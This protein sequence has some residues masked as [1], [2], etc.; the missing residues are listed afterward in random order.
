MKKNKTI[1]DA[2][3]LVFVHED[4]I[5]SIVRQNFLRAF[6]GY[7]AFPGGKVDKEDREYADFLLQAA[8]REA[9]EELGFDILNDAVISIDKIGL[10]LSPEFNPLRFNTHFYR[11]NLK[12]KPDFT[13]DENEAKSFCWLTP[14]QLLESYNRGERLVVPP[15]R[16]FLEAFREDLQFKHELTFK[17]RFDLKIEVPAIEPIKN[18]IQVMP[19]SLTVPPA[20]RTNAFL[21]GNEAKVLIDPSP[22]DEGELERFLYSIKDYKISKMMITHHH[23]DHHKYA[24]HIARK[25]GYDIHLS[26]DTYERILKYDEA[27]FEGIN[28]NFLKE[29]DV[30]CDWLDEQVQVIEVPGHDEGQLALMPTS[31]KWFLA[32][33]LFQGIGTVVVGGDEGDMT[34]YFETLEK[35][36]GLDPQCVVP[37]HGIALGGTNILKK[38]LEHRRF[39]E[40]QI[41]EMMAKEINV[42]EMLKAIYFD[43][44]ERI[45]K[46]ARANIESHI[47]K[48]LNDSKT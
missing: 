14:S 36:I 6:P 47:E 28:I 48:I 26:V 23:G 35:V 41:K 44:P 27:Y 11:V 8:R 37:S 1:R 32:G 33:D 17:D 30:L 31:K 5:F 34:K 22:M 29:G 10:A 39:R 45:L 13:V 2:V 38:T 7:T 16:F 46:Y 12:S 19:R 40:N 9:L 15:I 21:V 43:L 42:E 3:S 18:F 4:K 20:D 25:F 24:P